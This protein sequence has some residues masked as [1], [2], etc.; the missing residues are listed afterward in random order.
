VPNHQHLILQKTKP[1]TNYNAE[2]IEKQ[3][4]YWR[5]QASLGTKAVICRGKQNMRRI[6]QVQ[7]AAN[8]LAVL[9]ELHTD[10]LSNGRLRLSMAL[11]RINFNQ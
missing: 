9:D 10:G 11:H 3:T 2:S 4:M 5:R 1:K 7:F 8:L 6:F